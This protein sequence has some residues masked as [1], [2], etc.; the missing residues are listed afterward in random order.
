MHELG[1]GRK[2]DR[3]GL[4][5]GVDDDLGEVRG[6]GRAG[7]RGDRKAFLDQCREL[8]LAHPL[9]QRVSDERS[10]VSLCRKNSSPQNS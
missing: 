1:V 6:P 7:A 8:L 4:N 9:R 10:K 5:G 3:L 2:G